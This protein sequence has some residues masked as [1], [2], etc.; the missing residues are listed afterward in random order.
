[1][2][3][4]QQTLSSV[5]LYYFN[6]MRPLRR[7]YCFTWASPRQILRQGLRWELMIWE[8]ILGG[9][10]RKQGEKPKEALIGGLHYG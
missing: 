7:V 3:G 1:M 9:T 5:R 10:V 4:T 2:P 8:V 6:P